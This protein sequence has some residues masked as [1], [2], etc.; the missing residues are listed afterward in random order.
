MLAK[1]L[2]VGLLVALS[3][4]A[5]NTNNA[6]QKTVKETAPNTL[7]PQEKKEGWQLLFD[8]KS[9][10]GW[11]KYGGAKVGDAWVINDNSIHLDAGAKRNEW[12][13]AE[14]GD[15]VTDQA[16]GDFH[17][18]YDWK[19]DKGGNSGVIFYIHEDT[20]KYRW[21]WQTGPEMQV[22]DNERHSDAKIHKHRA[23]DLYDLI[24]SSSEP[25]K[26]ALEWN[27]AE[28]KSEKG[29]LNFYLNGVNV[30]S[31]Q[32][33]DD[34]WKALIAGSKF[35]DM[36]GFGTYREGKISLQDHGDKVWYRNIKIKKL[37]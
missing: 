37:K 3:L 25:V 19:V 14:G 23:G 27:H 33:W 6:Q 32:L 13:I 18:Q 1:K 8:G 12:Q 36:P 15:I 22:L 11:H 30:V 26:P 16:F 31:T 9:Y 10:K 35:K 17:L 4:I 7:T 34:A 28:I 20:T 29:K 2:G 24:A 21:G 5:C